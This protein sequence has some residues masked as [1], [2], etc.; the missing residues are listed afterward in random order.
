MGEN[1]ICVKILSFA[2]DIEPLLDQWFWPRKLEQ[3]K[4]GKQCQSQKIKCKWIL[5]DSWHFSNL[6]LL[7][8]LISHCWD[9]A[10][11]F[12]KLSLFTDTKV[13][14]WC[15]TVYCSFFQ[16]KLLSTYFHERTEWGVSVKLEDNF[17]SQ[18]RTTLISVVFHVLV[19]VSLFKQIKKR[20][21]KMA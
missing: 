8:V 14:N 7:R 2:L 1:I 11:N 10:H 3:E 15:H 16:S 13:L 21:E 18:N 4:Q 17:I 9:K 19:Y 12:M 20:R 6:A 5:K